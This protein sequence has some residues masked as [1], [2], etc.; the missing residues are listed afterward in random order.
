VTDDWGEE[1]GYQGMPI[2]QAVRNR[3]VRCAALAGYRPR[4]VMVT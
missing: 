2:V 4:A 3:Q 1:A